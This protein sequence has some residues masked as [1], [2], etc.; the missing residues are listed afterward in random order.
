MNPQEAD[1][2]HRE[3]HRLQ[4][5]EALTSFELRNSFNSLSPQFLTQTKTDPLHMDFF[6]CTHLVTT[7]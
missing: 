6:V 3:K 2:R 7:N 5:M 1:S 4:I